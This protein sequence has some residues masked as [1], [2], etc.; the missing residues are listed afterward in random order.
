M[1]C[2]DKILAYKAEEVA[3]A[4]RALPLADLKAKIADMPEPGGFAAALGTRIAHHGAALIGEIKK[5]SPSRGLIR[6]DFDPQ[7]LAI[8]YARGGAACLSVLTDGPGFQGSADHL[9]VA[10]AACSLPVLRKDFMIDPWQIF[11]ARSQGADCVLLIMAALT[12]DMA[13]SLAGIAAELGMDAIAEVHDEAELARAIDLPCAM[14]GIN[15]R[16]LTSFDVHLETSEKLGPLVPEHKIAI[17]ES[18][19][20]HADDVAR[21]RRAGIFACLVGESLMRADDMIAAM[22]VFTVNPAHRAT[23]H[24]AGTR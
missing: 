20:W 10:R 15:N 18:G 24:E 1:T 12:G 6:K 14:I 4:R 5:A 21:M 13:H 19:L 11:E 8:S 2:L 23:L 7:A 3:A 16:D 17:S 9:K 22:R